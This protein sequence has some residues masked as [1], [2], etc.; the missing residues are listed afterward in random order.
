MPGTFLSLLDKDCPVSGR[1]VVPRDQDD[2]RSCVHSIGAKYYI[3]Q[4]DKNRV[5]VKKWRKCRVDA[6]TW[7][8]FST[9]CVQTNKPHQD[10]KDEHGY[11]KTLAR[12]FEVEF[13]T[14]VVF[15]TDHYLSGER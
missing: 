13:F 10:W 12:D 7:T 3:E 11:S 14:K 8:E 9:P 1:I 2:F 6:S 4:G 15:T 5:A